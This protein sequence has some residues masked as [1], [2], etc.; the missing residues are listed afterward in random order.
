LGHQYPGAAIIAVDQSQ[1][2]LAVTAQ[3]LGAQIRRTEL[4]HADF[5]RLPDRVRDVDLAVAAFCLYHSP[6]PRRPLAEIARCLAQS[7]CAVVTTKS[8][9]S[10]LALD[11][12]VAGTELDAEATRRLSLYASF[13]SG[14]AEREIGA[15]GLIVRRRLDQK[16]TFRFEGHDHLAEYLVT[17]PKYELP[18]NLAHNAKKLADALRD[19]AP[20]EPVTTTSTVT[21]LVVGRP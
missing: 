11:I 20:D 7:G 9:D 8:A 5:H 19:R 6:D 16:H 17:C 2:L 10:Y 15:A 12:L 3:R 1:A 4:V 14:N 13:H 21:Y 18:A